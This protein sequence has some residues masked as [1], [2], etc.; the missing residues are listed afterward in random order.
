MMSKS[1]SVLVK[2]GLAGYGL[3]WHCVELIAEKD[4]KDKRKLWDELE[5]EAK[6]LARDSGLM[7]EESSPF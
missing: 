7:R 5:R 6:V 2:Y 3:Y 1:K 4:I